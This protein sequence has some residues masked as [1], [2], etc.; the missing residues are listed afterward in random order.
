MI[1]VFP[2][3]GGDCVLL[4]CHCLTSV[5]AAV[6]KHHSRVAEDEIH[7]PVNVAFSVELTVRMDVE[8]VLIPDYVAAV[9]HCMVGA[10]SKRNCLMPSRSSPILKCHVPQDYSGAG[11]RCEREKQNWIRMNYRP[12][13][14]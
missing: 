13:D 9:D 1:R 11:G 7:C 10:D 8:S 12:M 4:K 6:L 14:D 2:V 5:N 3:L